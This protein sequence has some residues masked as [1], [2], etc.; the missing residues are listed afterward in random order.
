VESELE[1]VDLEE[2]VVSNAERVQH[3]REKCVQGMIDKGVKRKKDWD[4]KAKE[5][6]FEVGEEILMRKP[7]LNLKLEESWEGPYVIK[8]RNSHVSYAVDTGERVIPSAHV[9]LLKKY[10][11][12]GEMPKVGRATSVLEPDSARDDVTDRYAE[13]KVTGDKL[14]ERQQQEIEELIEKHKQ[15]LT[16]K[17]SLA[18]RSTFTIDPGTH[19][20][21][22]QRA[23]NTP[24]S[25]R[26]SIDK[27]IDWLMEKGFFR[28]S[29]SPWASPM[30]MVKKPDGTARLCVDFKK[31]NEITTQVPFYMPRVEE[32][33]EGVGKAEYISKLDLSKGYYQIP[34]EE[35]DV[36]KTAFTCHRVPFGV[37]NAPAVFQELLQGLLEKEEK[38][39]RPYM[40]D[41]VVYSDSW[42]E[43]LQHIDRVL[44][45][46]GEA[47]LTA[48][49]NKCKWGGRKIEFLGHQI[50]NGKM[51]L[52]SHR[53]EAFKNYTKPTTKKG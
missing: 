15:T 36:E 46:L 16:K 24:A 44:N 18:N 47:G 5:R 28:K 32:V 34:M 20:L 9:Q 14:S 22:Y 12:Q 52:P 49:P 21:I 11:Q 43:H 26:E 31:I 51:S 42:E 13:M 29:Q 7:G 1:E 17:P 4:W 23:Y 50:G 53:A 45:K 6:I 25:L 38:F 27:E 35:S 8:K 48:N 3:N 40:D 2:W 39:S 19:E 10:H 37:K 41:I 30:V 33:L